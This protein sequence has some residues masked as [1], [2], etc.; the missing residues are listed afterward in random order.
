[1]MF[2]MSCSS[3]WFCKWCV[4][5]LHIQ[6]AV[7]FTVMVDE[8]PDCSNNGQVALV[9][10]WVDEDLAAHEDFIGLYLPD[11]VTAEAL[12]TIIQDTLLHMN[13]TLQHCRGQCYDEASTMC[14]TKKVLPRYLLIRSHGRYSPAATGT[15]SAW[16]LVMQSSSVSL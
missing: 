5:L 6:R 3:S 11:S 13:I 4:I 7:I 16:Q 1:M 15:P 8:T 12:V 9:F 2:K 14:G 10:R